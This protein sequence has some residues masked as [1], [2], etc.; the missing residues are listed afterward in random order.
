M[1]IETITVGGRSGEYHPVVL[2][3]SKHVFSGYR[4]SFK[5]G[6]TAESYPSTAMRF[7][8]S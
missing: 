5:E 4:I 1:A 6:S 7:Q 8:D 2:D 3:V